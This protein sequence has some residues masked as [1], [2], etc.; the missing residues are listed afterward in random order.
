MNKKPLLMCSIFL[1]CNCTN[2]S[3]SSEDTAPCTS[4]Y[5]VN[6]IQKEVK[7]LVLDENYLLIGYRFN[8][9][10]MKSSE[11]RF[12]DVE[13]INKKILIKDLKKQ[14]ILFILMEK[15][16]I[17]IQHLIFVIIMKI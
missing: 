16:K 2:N 11:A 6:F 9:E 10:T 8:E 7:S 17:T 5:S 3:L 12:V 15:I 13:V 1:L 14:Q 4:T